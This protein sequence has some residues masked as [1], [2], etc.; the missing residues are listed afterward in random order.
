MFLS[1]FYPGN[2]PVYISRKDVLDPYWFPEGLPGFTFKHVEWGRETF[3]RK[4]NKKRTN[5]DKT[6]SASMIEHFFTNFPNLASDKA[7]IIHQS[8][9]VL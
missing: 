8:I 1:K 3:S 6:Q 4:Q 2:S 5:N 7:S 9:I